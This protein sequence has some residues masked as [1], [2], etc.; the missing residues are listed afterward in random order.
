MKIKT[1][2][3]TVLG[4]FA[5]REGFP[6]IFCPPELQPQSDPAAEDRP[7]PTTLGLSFNVERIADKGEDAEPLLIERGDFAVV[8]VFDGMGGAGATICDGPGGRR[9]GAYYGAT[10][11]RGFIR[12]IAERDVALLASATA[13]EIASRIYD[14]LATK[15]EQ[16]A[17]LLDIHESKLRSTL[18]RR[19][20]TTSAIG[21]VRGDGRELVVFWAGDSRVYR[22]TPAGLS[23]LTRDHLRDE[24]D[25]LENLERDTPLANCV[26]ADRTFSIAWRQF[27]VAE[28][29]IVISATDGCFGFVA[30][31]MHF[32]QL[33][34][35]TMAAASSMDDW[36]A[37]LVIAIGA[38]AGDDISM[39]ALAIGWPTFDAM[40]D[41]FTD[42]RKTVAEDVV[43]RIERLDADF[44]ETS[45]RLAQLE[46]E[47]RTAK[48]AAWEAYRTSYDVAA[49]VVGSGEATRARG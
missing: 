9:T 44:A 25:A 17:G 32:E 36:R 1:V 10:L 45:A 14:D 37:R 20:P 47:R 19:L 6:R 46:E 7:A 24:S 28:P 4:F 21:L 27:S 34:L 42:R 26:H 38:L 22:F 40:R 29:Y 33:L 15:L 23:Q 12:D 48:T 43:R 3:R 49:N 2:A 16:S 41:A 8:A 13:E 11:A 31:P 30:S 18:L 5:K 35:D 39:A